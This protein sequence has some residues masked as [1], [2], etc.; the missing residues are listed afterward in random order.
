MRPACP[1]ACDGFEGWSPEPGARLQHWGPAPAGSARR[2]P[3]CRARSSGAS[4]S[5]A[6]TLSERTSAPMSGQ[7]RTRLHNNMCLVSRS[8]SVCKPGFVSITVRH[9]VLRMGLCRLD[10]RDGGHRAGARTVAVALQ[11]HGARA[12]QLVGG[13]VP[14]QHV[15]RQPSLIRHLANIKRRHLSA[16]HDSGDCKTSVRY[17]LHQH[18]VLARDG[19]GTAKVWCCSCPKCWFASALGK[20]DLR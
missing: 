9:I 3:A 20:A 15:L 14:H 18:R 16:H 5:T 4:D 13:L 1:L 2:W 12:H 11:I 7:T 6:S 8:P 10:R 17:P 19:P